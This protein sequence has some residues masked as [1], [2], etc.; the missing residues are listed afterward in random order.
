MTSKLVEPTWD[1]DVATA[2]VSEHAHAIDPIVEAR[3]IRKID[4]FMILAMIIGYGFVYYDKASPILLRIV[5][6]C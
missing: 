3:V 4:R 2:I 1:R 5:P 6:N